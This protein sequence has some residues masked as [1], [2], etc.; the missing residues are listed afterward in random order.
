MAHSLKGL[1]GDRVIG[2]PLDVTQ[3]ASVA[4]AFE[5]TVAALRR[6]RH[7]HHQRRPGA[8]VSLMEMDLEAFRALERVNVEGTLL[9]LAQA[10]KIFRLQN[11][12][13]DIVLVST[14]N[15]FAPGAGF[16]AYSATKAAAHQLCRIA[17]P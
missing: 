13:G 6:N 14:K 16:G 7:P 11:I 1:Y 10:G 4:A 5:K 12:G 9:L 3:G 15:V 2:V 17:K 8:R